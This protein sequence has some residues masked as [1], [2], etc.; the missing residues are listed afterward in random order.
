[1]VIGGLALSDFVWL[2]YLF[3]L[4]RAV[5]SDDNHRLAVGVRIDLVAAQADHVAVGIN[6]RFGNPSPH[7]LTTVGLVE[8]N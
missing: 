5:I 1:M 2:S 6:D 4:P 8:T 3:E 7:R